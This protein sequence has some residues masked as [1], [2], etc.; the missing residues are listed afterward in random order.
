MPYGS[1]GLLGKCFGHDLGFS[2]STFY[3]YIIMYIY[4]YMCICIIYILYILF[5]EQKIYQHYRNFYRFQRNGD[6]SGF[7]TAEAQTDSGT[8]VVHPACFQGSWWQSLVDHPSSGSGWSPGS[9]NEEQRSVIDLDDFEILWV[10]L[11][12][13]YIDYKSK[14]GVNCCLSMFNYDQI[15]MCIGSIL[16]NPVKSSANICKICLFAA[17]LSG[18]KLRLV[19][20]PGFSLLCWANAPETRLWR[21]LQWYCVPVMATR[22]RLPR[23]AQLWPAPS[24]CFLVETLDDEDIRPLFPHGFSNVLQFPPRFCR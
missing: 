2:V 19:V 20:L 22:L 7:L 5:I 9:E 3:I 4:I 17:V 13:I 14:I 6:S 15:P 21:L 12:L 8:T 24:G 23:F 11:N 16:K 18:E 10:N 1:K